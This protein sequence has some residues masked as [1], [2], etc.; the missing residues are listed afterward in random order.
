MR[1]YTI[2]ISD[3]VTGQ[4]SVPDYDNREVAGFKK[5]DASTGAITF[6]SMVNGVTNPNALHIEMDVPVVAFHT[7][8]GAAWMRV[9]GIGLKQ[10]SQAASLNGKVIE[11]YAGMAKGLPLANPEQ[12][13]LIARGQIQ[14]CYG[15]WIGVNQTLEFVFGPAFGSPGQPA[16]I[17][18]DWRAG[19]Q[20]SDAINT[21][22]QT[23]FPTYSRSI[24]I[25]N[26]LVLAHDEPG[27]HQTLTQFAQYINDVSK[28]IIGGSYTGVKMTIRD[29]S[30][31]VFDGTSQSTPK[32][33]AFFDM[34]GQPTWG[35]PGNIQIQCVMT[36]KLQVGDFIVMPQGSV[37]NTPQSQSQYRNTSA[38]QGV[39][40]IGKLRHV[41]AFRHPDGE[42]WVTVVDAYQE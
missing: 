36:S 26:K 17:V 6:S 8:A 29:K 5:V 9:F 42:S 33:I 23:A 28:P 15:N 39:F 12:Y 31:V 10:I 20:L 37:I 19:M 38:F 11:I 18:I 30:F 14:Q 41:G 1:S 22:L 34:I 4:I 2:K 25:S 32:Q 35:D 16:N 3:Q 21:A 40:Q 27:A 24:N 7:P 13:G